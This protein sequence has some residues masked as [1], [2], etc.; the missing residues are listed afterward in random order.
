MLESR[1]CDIEGWPDNRSCENLVAWC[2]QSG[3]R[4]HLVVVNLS[5][6]D[7]QGQV[8]LPWDEL[9]GYSWELHDLPTG[10][11][12]RRDGRELRKT[13]LY[14]DLGPWKFHLFALSRQG[15]E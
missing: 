2:W 15:R 13:G 14:V 10:Q 1:L 5:E 7:S 12:Y 4:R 6:W 3:D 9:G 11:V 8:R